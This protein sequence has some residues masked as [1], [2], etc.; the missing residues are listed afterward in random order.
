VTGATPAAQPGIAKA[1]EGPRQRKQR[2]SPLE[3]A[4]GGRVIGN[5]A[6]TVLIG[7]IAVFFSL[8]NGERIKVKGNRHIGL[9][10]YSPGSVASGRSDACSLAFLNIAP[11]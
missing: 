8:R 2:W 5:G 3:K 6:T 9:A 11:W 4:S 7:N 10:V 1:G